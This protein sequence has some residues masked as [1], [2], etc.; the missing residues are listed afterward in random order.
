MQ[1]LI[2][3]FGDHS[4]I[5]AELEEGYSITVI[6]YGANLNSFV[7]DGFE[8]IRGHR[9]PEELEYH[10][11]AAGCTV[12]IPFANRVKGGLYT[13]KGRKFQLPI[14]ELARGNALH[15]FLTSTEWRVS[16]IYKGSDY[17]VGRKGSSRAP[18]N[19]AGVILNYDFRGFI[20]YPFKFKAETE[21][22][23]S[24]QGLWVRLT[25]KNTGRSEMP[26]T[27]G[28]HPYFVVDGKLDEWKLDGRSKG[29]LK[30]IDLIP[31]GELEDVTFAGK[32]N[33]RVFDDCYVADGEV[34][35]QG[36]RKGLI[37]RPNENPYIQIYTPPARDS[38]AIEP[39]TG[40]AD[41]FN[42]GIGLKVLKPG[43]KLDATYEVVPFSL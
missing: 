1:D 39:M 36:I 3:G 41:S 20:G 17:L 4:A 9:T 12:M 40:V 18:R 22:S 31:T 27:L 26:L 5:K 11:T 19:G 6:D 8:H 24:R 30:V 25:V 35:L 10:S 15:G 13:F 33:G 37:I 2:S 28:T 43:E 14:N 38:L 23:I 42:N 16:S 34:K 21:Y 29:R 7:Y 32:V